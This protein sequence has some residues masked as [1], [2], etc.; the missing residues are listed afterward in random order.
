MEQ[1]TQSLQAQDSPH[2]LVGV[3]PPGLPA[4]HGVQKQGQVRR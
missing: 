2:V 3:L 4:E 1:G